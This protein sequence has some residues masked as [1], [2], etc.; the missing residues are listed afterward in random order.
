MTR[1]PPVAA[2][3]LSALPPKPYP[4]LRPFDKSEWTIFFGR[5]RMTGEVIDRLIQD[6]LVV[7]HGDSGSGKSSLV[8]AGVLAELE[9][10]HSRRGLAWRTAVLRP[11]EGPIEGLA[12]VL[13]PLVPEPKADSLE[14][15]H[16]ILNLGRDAP[17]ALAALLRRDA[18]DQVCILIDQFEELFGYAREEDASEAALLVEILI[19]LQQQEPDGLYAILTMRSEFLGACARYDD[20]A[21]VVNATQYLLPQIDRPALLRAIHEPARLYGGTVQR[22]L[23]ERLID[24]VDGSQDQLP[25]IQHGLMLLVQRKLAVAAGRDNAGWRLSEADVEGSGG[26]AQILSDH[27]DAVMAEAAPEEDDRKTLEHLFR[28]L[29]DINAEG[30]AVRRPQSLASLC[31]VTGAG[32]ERLGPILEAFRADGVSFLKPYGDAALDA[33]ASIDISHEALIRCWRKVADRKEGWLQ[34]EFRDGLTWQTLRVHS[35]TLSAAATEEYDDWLRGLP[36]RA[37]AER[38][39]GGW[40]QVDDLMQRSRKARA[41][42]LRKDRVIRYGS[43]AVAVVFVILAAL[44]YF[45]MERAER[46]KAEAQIGD[47]LFRAE[48]ARRMLDEGYPVTAVQLALAG[49]PS[50]PNLEERPWVAETA[51]ALVEAMG[52]VRELSVLRGHKENVNAVSYSPDGARLASVSDD[53]TIRIWDAETGLELQVLR[54]HEEGVESVSFSPDGTRLASGSLDGTIRIWGAENGVELQVLRGHEEIAKGFVG[55]VDTV[56]YSPDGM[57]L[58]SGSSDNTIRIW[59][60]ETGVELQVLRGH[61]ATVETISFSLDGTRLASGSRDDTIRI[62]DVESGMELQVLRGHEAVVESVSY[63]PDGARL[64]SGSSDGTIWIWDV[65]GGVESQVLRGHEHGVTSVSYSPDGTRL[66]SGSWDNTIRIWDTDDGVESQILRGH[67]HGVTSV[68]YSPDGTDLVSGSRDNTIRLWS[69]D[70]GVELQILRGH[71]QGVTSVTYSP[72]GARLASGSSDGT[73]WIW[74]VKG[75]VESQVLRGHEHGVTSV[76]YSPDGTRLASGSWD[77]TIR[78]WDAEAGVELQILTGH[79]DGVTS[80]SYSPDG[81]RLA[82][83]SWDDT[84]RIWDVESGMELQVLRGHELY[85]T[86]VSFSLD[87][88]RIASGSVD[89]TIRVWNAENG[90]ELHDFIGHE[91]TVNS[92]VFSPDGTRLASGST[93]GTIRVWDTETGAELQTLIG[94]DGPIES[95]GYSSD[96]ARLVSGAWDGA[97]RVWDPASGADLQVIRGYNARTMSV[98]Y[99]PDRTRL[100]SGSGEGTITIVWVG[101]SKKALIERARNRL[102]RNMTDEEKRKFYVNVVPK[103]PW[104]RLLSQVGL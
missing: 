61:S 63:S 90:S 92:I 78:I 96:G 33:S 77:N 2:H 81:T 15:I 27:A 49:L 5:E 86:S 62:W 65:K 22:E 4:G 35:G 98:S 89:N 23:A 25:L 20:L 28:A 58:A 36:S 13:L 14:R 57:R 53:D 74:D 17:R 55:S 34:R 51:G 75:G 73:I 76:S 97:I 12:K 8:R 68:S 59:D 21:E 39:G 70:D 40:P 87:G 85:I 48:Q 99:S 104:W 3:P 47:S 83:G 24:E 45:G 52:S 10:E 71:E 16:G 11:S 102:T 84:I 67:E 6:H 103:E 7:V 101:A 29:T 18:R 95:V 69:P 100:V 41:A 19:G 30:S 37:W 60:A 94:H 1:P 56:S 32:E 43:I 42:Q 46:A 82:S 66:A 31:A 91:D 54:G 44:S 64:A 72:D 79:E 80:V 38:Y 50:D 26:L 93:D 88:T 9:Q